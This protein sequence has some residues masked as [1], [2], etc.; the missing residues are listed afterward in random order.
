MSRT[1]GDRVSSR[2]AAAGAFCDI[3]L[4]PA[5]PVS[6]AD[7]GQAQLGAVRRLLDRLALYL[8]LIYE[9]L[10]ASCAEAVRAEP[11]LHLRM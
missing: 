11:E 9:D 6:P 3:E 8:W 4:G 2:L 7:T 10:C 1:A 5:A